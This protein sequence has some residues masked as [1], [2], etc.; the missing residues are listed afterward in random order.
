MT[1]FSVSDAA[2]E[3]SESC[4]QPKVKASF[5]NP[6]DIQYVL[7]STDHSPVSCLSLNPNST[8]IKNSLIATHVDGTLEYWHATS[9]QLLFSKKVLF[10]KI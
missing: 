1:C 4:P 3:P 6:G 2:M 9:Q 7:K 10:V 5:I 8:N